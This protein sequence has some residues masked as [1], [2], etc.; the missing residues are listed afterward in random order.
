MANEVTRNQWREELHRKLLGCSTLWHQKG[1]PRI[2]AQ[3]Q[4]L[5]PLVAF[6]TAHALEPQ[7]LKSEDFWNSILAL[8]MVHEASLLHDDIIDEAPLR[9]GVP[10]VYAKHGTA[11]ALVAGDH[12]LTS[13]YRV[14]S[15]TQNTALISRFCEAVEQTVAGEIAQA[16]SAGKEIS[17]E[18]YEEI[19]LG[20]SGVLFGLAMSIVPLLLKD[21]RAPDF[22]SWG[23]QLGCLYQR[24]DDFLDYCS[25]STTGKSALQD[26]HQK[27]STWVWLALPEPRWDLDEQTIQKTLFSQTDSATSFAR[28]LQSQ[29]DTAR[30]D[31]Q[32]QLYTLLGAHDEGLRALLGDWSLRFQSARLTEESEL[33][34]ERER[35]QHSESSVDC[36]SEVDLTSNA[37][38]SDISFV[39][40]E[41]SSTQPM[42]V[43]SDSTLGGDRLHMLI[44]QEQLA[45][46]EQWA[47][48]FAHNSRSF[49]FAARWFPP[50][51]REQIAGVYAY[52]R[53]T[54]ELADGFG[55]LCADERLALLEEW[56]ALSE[57]AFK[58]KP[59][60]IPLLDRVMSEV[61]TYDVPFQVVRDLIRGM[62][63]DLEPKPFG[64][65]QELLGYCYCVASTVGLWCTHLFSS[66]S[67]WVLKRADALGK[68]MQLTNILRDVGEDLERERVYLPYDVM[69][70]YAITEE[71]LRAMQ[72]GEQ[73]I[74][75]AYIDLLEELIEEA[76]QLYTTAYEGIPALPSFFA[77]PVAIAAFVY[78]GIHREIRRNRYD[79]LTKR[80]RT[81]TGRK[82]WLAVRGLWKLGRM[83]WSHWRNPALQDG[84][85]F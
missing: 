72:S 39:S 74:S 43:S 13:A 34:L 52:C 75:Q 32:T 51:Q 30:R 24:L 56:E 19:I 84:R 45:S 67:A 21:E 12:L 26:Y 4:L 63:M 78:R 28:S 15:T 60:K 66:P 85:T 10:T 5:R 82:I 70:K 64:S 11:A 33:L 65:M 9:R 44:S 47:E 20:K 59:T 81:S 79:N 38:A 62:R 46:P 68:A 3:G 2:A 36:T 25:H 71:R 14:I 48:Y 22:W 17:S 29:F 76:E 49:S 50:Q 73:P 69:Q 41:R 16:K 35:I 55:E 23:S 31:L 57:A 40:I 1:L 27:K 83:R 54:D 80:A 42:D 58:G 7:L 6:R 53:C 37:S 61:R 18:T 8:Q 77:T